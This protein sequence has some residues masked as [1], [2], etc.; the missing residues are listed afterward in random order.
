MFSWKRPAA[1]SSLIHRLRFLRGNWRLLALWPVVALLLITVGW[2]LLLTQL[3]KE[4]AAAQNVVLKEAAS[5]AVEYADQLGRLMEAVDEFSLYVRRA[6]EASGGAFHLEHWAADKA[7]RS[8]WP[9]NVAIVAPNGDVVSSRMQLRPGIN[10]SGKSFFDTHKTTSGDFLFVSG[11][12]VNPLDNMHVV[13]FTRKLTAPDGSFA[14]VVMVCLPLSR[15]TA[16]YNLALLGEHGLMSA[17]GTDGAVRASRSGNVVQPSENLAAQP[18]TALISNGTKPGLAS[19]HWFADG[20]SRYVSWR[21]VDAYP[22]VAVVGLDHAEK[23]A[24]YFATRRA[25]IRSA[26]WATGAILLF[27]FIAMGLTARLAWRKHEMELAQATYRIA[28]EEGSE[29]FYIA[30]P[31]FGDEGRIEDFTVIDCNQSGAEFFRMSRGQLIGQTV[32]S[33]YNGR[34]PVRLMNALC[35]AQQHGTFEDEIEVRTEGLVTTGW[36]HLKVVRADGELAVRLRDVS[37]AKA[38]IREL[39]RQASEDVLT[40]L[41][42]RQ[43]VLGYLPDAV[44]AAAQR[45]TLLA[46]LFLDLDGFKLIN[47]TMGHSAGDELLQLAARRLTLAVRPEDHVARLGGDEFVVLVEGIQYARDA[48]NVAERVLHAFKENFK[49]AQGTATIGTS[50]GISMYPKDG[51]DAESLLKNADI[52][53]YSVKSVG[54]GGYRFYNEQLYDALKQR[55]AKEAELR[56]ALERDELVVHYQPRVDIASGKVASMEALVRWAHPSKGLLQPNDFISV[57]EQAGL[58]AQLGEVV[59]DKVCAQLA[60]WK[61]SGAEVPPVSVNVSARQFGDT[62]MP[63]VFSAALQR[64][65][66][67]ASLIEIELTES[68]MMAETQDVDDALNALQEMG[69]RLL[70]DDFGTGYSSLSQLQRLDF[71][72]LKVD[73]AFTAE[74]E[75]NEQ[76][77]VF[78]TAIITMAHALGMRVVAEGVENVQQIRILKALNCDEMQGYFIAPPKPAEQSPEMLPPTLF[79]V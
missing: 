23:L 3:E 10:L 21:K 36:L 26:W 29:G 48:G 38:H 74:I 6:W 33:L 31:V 65:G 75:K 25:A 73:R 24:P 28:T 32:K 14:G 64:H 22:L 49:L 46:L 13:N 41:P 37:A 70:V 40:R 60:R 7:A 56:Q 68:L 39:E 54:K 27:K 16:G 69:I 20:R 78:F 50:I 58:I 2:S 76:G 15:L 43:W 8:R 67:D 55:M 59:L 44:A 63:D 35:Y 79:A 62:D 61:A 42:N 4:K 34:D 5:S 77:N 45:Q 53:M 12:N 66:L 30:R 11:P 52:A 47:D 72:V 51:L 17:V 18:L 9:F 71:D 57:A 19:G 1:L